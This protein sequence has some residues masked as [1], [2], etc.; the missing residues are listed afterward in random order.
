MIVYARFIKQLMSSRLFRPDG[1]VEAT[2]DPAVWT[3]AHRGYSGSGRLDVR[4]YPSKKA[5]LHE[6]AKLAVACG[7]DEDEQ[8]TDLFAGGRYDQVPQ[9]CDDTH[10]ETHLLRVHAAF[11]QTMMTPR[12]GRR[13]CE[14]PE[15]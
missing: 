3:L 1:T 5:A 15:P 4:E 13:K 12:Q 8:A 9:R 2:Q 7:M 10:P 14:A 6:G 11:L